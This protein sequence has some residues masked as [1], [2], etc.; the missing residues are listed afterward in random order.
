MQY[1]LPKSK[2]DYPKIIESLKSYSQE[3]QRVIMAEFKKF[4]KDKE[5]YIKENNVMYEII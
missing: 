1:Q 3:E 5:K 2:D 4:L